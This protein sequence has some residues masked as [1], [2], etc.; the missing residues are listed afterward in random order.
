MEK[1]E[2]RL[3]SVNAKEKKKLV[4]NYRIITAVKGRQEYHRGE[5]MYQSYSKETFF[6][7]VLYVLRVKQN[8]NKLANHFHNIDENKSCLKKGICICIINI[9]FIWQWSRTL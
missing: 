3:L 9:P 5:M 8:T 4:V 6:T 1:Y 7:C 2:E